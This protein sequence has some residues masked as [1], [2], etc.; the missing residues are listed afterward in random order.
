M[1]S[2]MLANSFCL[3][4]FAADAPKGEDSVTKTS[5]GAQSSLRA[6]LPPPAPLAVG[7]V[8]TRPRGL[9]VCWP[10]SVSFKRRPKSSNF[11]LC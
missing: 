5:V 6:L 1:V 11:A 8:L 4:F 2:W 9:P 3:T 10:P 7:P